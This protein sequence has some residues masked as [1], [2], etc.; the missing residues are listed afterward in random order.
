MFTTLKLLSI[1]G[2]TCDMLFMIFI[3]LQPVI[4]ELKMEEACSSNPKHEWNQ[5]R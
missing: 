3:K 1:F 4:N 5:L 2:G